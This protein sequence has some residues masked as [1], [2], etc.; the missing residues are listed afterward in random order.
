M[1]QFYTKYILKCEIKCIFITI[2]AKTQPNNFLLDNNIGRIDIY[3]IE[4]LCHMPFDIDL[5]D[6]L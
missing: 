3:Y 6:S 5:E 4:R 2:P 1:L